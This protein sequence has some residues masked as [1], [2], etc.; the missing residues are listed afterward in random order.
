[1]AFGAAIFT[2]LLY[3]QF[4]GHRQVRPYV[5]WALTAL[6]FVIFG[7]GEFILAYVFLARCC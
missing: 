1:M 7:F 2:V 4:T 5:L 3:W 6:A